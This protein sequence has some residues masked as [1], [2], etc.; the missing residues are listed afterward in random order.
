MNV[1][2]IAEN[3]SVG[4]TYADALDLENPQK[5][6]GFISYPNFF[7]LIVPFSKYHRLMI[8]NRK[9]WKQIIHIILRCND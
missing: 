4:R 5:K 9:F 1:V 8:E 3:P 2:M 6:E 7:D